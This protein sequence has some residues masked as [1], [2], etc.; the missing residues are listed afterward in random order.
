MRTR[1]LDL[2]DATEGEIVDE[3]SKK[4]KKVKKSKKE[5]KAKSEKERSSKKRKLEEPESDAAAASVPVTKRP[6]TRSFELK[7]K[8]EAEAKKQAETKEVVQNDEG[9]D[10]K[11]NKPLSAFRIS[12]QSMATLKARGMTHLFPIQVPFFRI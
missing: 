11:G 5:K 2:A 7:M 12:P 10:E 6:R 4:E 3:S 8:Q 1:S 9:L